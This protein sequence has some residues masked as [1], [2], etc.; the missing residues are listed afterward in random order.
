VKAKD[1]LGITAA[2][3]KSMRRTAKYARM[4]LKTIKGVQTYRVLDKVLKYKHVNRMQRDILT[5]PQGLR[6]RGH[7]V[8]RLLEDKSWNGSTVI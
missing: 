7:R 2:E 1:T 8:K 4:D 6:N 3:M 5:K